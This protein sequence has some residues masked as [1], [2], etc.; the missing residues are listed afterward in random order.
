MKSKIAEC[1]NR[2][3]ATYDQSCE[4]QERAN[5]HLI[6]FLKPHRTAFNKVSDLGCGTGNSIKHSLNALACDEIFAVDFSKTL[7]KTAQNKTEDKKIIFINQDFEKKIF[8]ANS[9]DLIY[10]NM[11]FQWCKNISH[12]FNT[13]SKQLA[14]HGILA[15]SCVLEGTYPELYLK[16]K[17]HTSDRILNMLEK[18]GFKLLSYETDTITL[19]FDNLMETLKSIKRVGASVKTYDKQT[20]GLITLNQLKEKYQVLENKLIYKIGYFIAKKAHEN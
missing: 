7:L 3:A 8:K 15:F 16:N 4:L 20:K 13:L 9:L 5:F 12:L 17:F 1:F 11:S 10:S 18:N 6:E 14:K 2:S 19:K